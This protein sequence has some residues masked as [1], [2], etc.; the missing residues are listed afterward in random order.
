M[1][2]NRLLIAFLASLKNNK[3]IHVFVLCMAFIIKA[4]AQDNQQLQITGTVKDELNVTV[5]GVTVK[6]LNSKKVTITDVKGHFNILASKG[7]SLS[8]KFIGY[9]TS[10]VVIRDEINLTITLQGEANSLNEVAVVGYGQQ[11]KPSLVG[12]Q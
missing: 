8:V 12:A 6:N 7:D 3:Y 9:R 2:K 10:T 1:S 5:P 4:H 11:K